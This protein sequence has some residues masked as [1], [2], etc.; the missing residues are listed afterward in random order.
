MFP[1]PTDSRLQLIGKTIC[2][3]LSAFG[4][5]LFAQVI[6]FDELDLVSVGWVRVS[7]CQGFVYCADRLAACS[8]K[9]LLPPLLYPVNLAPHSPLDESATLRR[10]RRLN[11]QLVGLDMV[12]VAS[13]TW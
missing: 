6:H 12:G 10:I 2:E 3:I 11:V 13:H 1:L 7:W 4:E 5:D 9:F 8:K